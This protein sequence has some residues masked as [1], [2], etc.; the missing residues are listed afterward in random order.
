VLEI[1]KP[2]MGDLLR[3]S[4]QCLNSL[5]ELLAT[6]KLETEGLVRDAMQPEANAEKQREY[7]ASFMRRLRSFF[8]L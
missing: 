8:S 2:V 1:S 6:R 4:P 3:S 7:T 5:S